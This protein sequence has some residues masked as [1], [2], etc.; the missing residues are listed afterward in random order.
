MFN[1]CLQGNIKIQ[2]SK[3][4][5]KRFSKQVRNVMKLVKVFNAMIL[6]VVTRNVVCTEEKTKTQPDN[7]VCANR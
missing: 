1:E 5:L 7:S 2:N 3:C 6:E 4:S